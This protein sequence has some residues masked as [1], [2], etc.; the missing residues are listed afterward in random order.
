MSRHFFLLLRIFIYIICRISIIENIMNCGKRIK[1][2]CDLHNVKQTWLAERLGIDD[3]TLSG[4][5]YKS[6]LHVNKIEQVCNI[7]QMNL[8]E[9]FISHDTNI[10]KFRP[11]YITDDD[12]KIL[13]TLN[14][15]IPVEK[16]LIIK[17]ICADAV[18]LALGS[19]SNLF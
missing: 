17:R 9:F 16:R 6:S 8:Y 19:N 7:F 5:I 14:T 12:D 11:S 2:L 1:E 4:W 15:R 3:N 13:R 10:E 18:E